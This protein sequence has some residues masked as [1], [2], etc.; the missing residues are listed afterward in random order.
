MNRFKSFSED[1]K[2]MFSTP[3]GPASLKPSTNPRRVWIAVLFFALTLI[4]GLLFGI[5]AGRTSGSNSNS[6]ASSNGS[7]HEERIGESGHL[8]IQFSS[9]NGQ[10]VKKGIQAS[11]GTLVRVRLLN[12]LETFDTVPA[13][14]QITDYGLG[15]RYF[16]WTLVGDASSDANVERIKI[17]FQSIKSP[18]NQSALS[19]K[20]NALSLD[21]TLGVRAKKIEGLAARSLI[22]GSRAG[23]SGMGNSIRQSGDLSSLLLRALVQ[24]LESEI[25][26][27][28]GAAYN[29]ASALELKP[30]AEFFVQLTESF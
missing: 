13:F 27:D 12:Q 18:S 19:F 10:S 23:A 6:S 16:G 21:G 28:L 8:V 17:S 15:H 3:Q 1:L 22:A 29:R 26:S 4:A 24:G 30:G 11:E 7:Q 9:S 14:A 25:S 2:G 20:G 5:L